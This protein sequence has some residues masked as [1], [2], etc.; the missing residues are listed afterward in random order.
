ME[1]F[2]STFTIGFREFFRIIVP[3][4]LGVT[5]I[6]L[7]FPNLLANK[8]YELPFTYLFMIAFFIGLITY[9]LQTTINKVEKKPWSRILFWSEAFHNEIGRLDHEVE[10]ALGSIKPI[11]NSGYDPEYK[12]FLESRVTV[13]LLKEYITSLF[14][15]TYSSK[16]LNY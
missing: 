13:L 12:Y 15:I 5:F 1:R 2:S 7:E 9:I 8:G 6:R 14:S 4:L 16:Y 10:I 11:S 3:G